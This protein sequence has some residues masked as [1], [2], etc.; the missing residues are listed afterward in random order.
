MTRTSSRGVRVGEARKPGPASPPFL[1]LWSINCRSFRKNGFM[2]LDEAK[3]GGVQMVA[4]QETNLTAQQTIS[5]DHTCRSKGWQLLHAPLPSFGTNRGGV[6]LAVQL[7]FGACR[8]AQRESPPP[9]VLE[10]SGK[11]VTSHGEA[12]EVLHS[13]WGEVFGCNTPLVDVEAFFGQFPNSIPGAQPGPI[14]PK[15]SCKDVKKAAMDMPT[16]AAGPDGWQA[17]WIRD[18]PQ[19]ALIRLASLYGACERKG[20]WPEPLLHWRLVFLPKPKKNRWPTPLEMR[21]ICI[22]SILYRIWSRVRLTHLQGFLAQFLAPLQS[23]GIGGPSESVQDLLLSWHQEFSGHE[24]ALA[25]DYTKA[26][27]SMGYNLPIAIMERVGVPSQICN[28]LRNQWENHKRW[29]CFSGTVFSKPLLQAKGL[30]QGDGWSPIALSLVLSVVQRCQINQVPCANTMLYLDDRTILARNVNHINSSLNVW[31]RLQTVTRMRTNASKTQPIARTWD[32]Y[33]QFEQQGWTPQAVGTILGVSLGIFPRGPS[34]KEQDR[35]RGLLRVA[36]RV[37]LLPVSSRSRAVLASLVLTS[38]ASWGA[39]F[40]GRV[41]SNTALTKAFGLAIHYP[42]VKLHSSPDL[43]RFFLWGHR[44]DL[45]LVA[46]QNLLVAFTRWRSARPHLAHVPNTPLML[47]LRR[48][49]SKLQCNLSDLGHVSWAHG[50]WD[51]TSPAAWTSRLAHNLRE[52]WPRNLLTA[53]LRSSR[54]DS[55][56]ARGVHLVFT[57]PLW[58]NFINLAC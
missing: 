55:A 27:D 10:N 46:R 4:L 26:F 12:A 40:N 15:I 49:L 30:P 38:K 33:V 56:I 41:P 47:A 8:W 2:L 16:K 32:A 13:A 31:Q 3:A 28:L 53:W 25:L 23:G 7:P 48:S 17:A 54:N 34:Q 14:L 5:V 18:L 24:Y 50:S 57:L 6:A 43:R 52:F 42:Y 1:K 29:C 44:S 45:Q 19:E 36:R 21:P 11:V 9:M 58:I 39:I 22:G 35:E 20:V 51:T 37:G